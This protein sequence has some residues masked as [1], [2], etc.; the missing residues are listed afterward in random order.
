MLTIDSKPLLYRDLAVMKK[1]M[2]PVKRR[3][4][5]SGTPEDRLKAARSAFLRDNR[6]VTA[7]EDRSGV[8]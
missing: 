2:L 7:T 5:E 1:Q 6:L 4:R 3:G 8:P